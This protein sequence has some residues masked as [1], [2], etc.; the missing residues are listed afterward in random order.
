MSV[1]TNV[2]LKT[3]LF[4][5][6]EKEHFEKEINSFFDTKGFVN[7]DDKSLPVGWYGGTK[8]LEAELWLGSFNYLDLEGLVNHLKSIDWKVEYEDWVQ[9]IYQKQEDDK[10]SIIEFK[11]YES[12]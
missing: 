11:V 9:V 8:M 10:F 2:I 3:P 12:N 1:V 4:S 6:S 7:C 5:D